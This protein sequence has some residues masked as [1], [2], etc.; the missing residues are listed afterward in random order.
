MTISSK[1]FKF[2]MIL[3]SLLWI[4][5]SV[6]TFAKNDTLIIVCILMLVNGIL[7]FVFSQI[8][9]ENKLVQSAIFLFLAANLILTFTDQMG[10]FD[11]LVMIFNILSIVSLIVY[12]PKKKNYKK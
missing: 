11:Y 8:F 4:I 3:Q 10:F 6:V 5:F 9:Q 1:I 7:F 12:I 2:N